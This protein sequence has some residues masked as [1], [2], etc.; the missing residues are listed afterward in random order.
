MP[1]I[2]KNLGIPDKKIQLPI[3]N[4]TSSKE[5]IILDEDD[6]NFIR[7]RFKDDFELY[8]EVNNKKGLFKMVI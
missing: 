6:L 3:A 7:R 8:N 1:Y 4:V 5:D 2:L